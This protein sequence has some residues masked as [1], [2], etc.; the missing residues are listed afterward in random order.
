MIGHVQSRKAVDVAGSFSWVHSV[1]SLKLASRLSTFAGQAGCELQVLLEVNVGGEESK[2]GFPAHDQA[3]FQAKLG[4]IEQILQLPN[5]HVRGLMSMAPMTAEGEKA[6]PFFERTRLIRDELS[7][8][9]PSARW[10]QLSMG[11]S[12]DFEAAILEGA[13]MVRIGTAILG[14]RS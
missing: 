2:H 9:F 14:P 13:T 5:V 12:G 11:M 1:D 7:A 8:K 6:R 3:A 10:E 4:E